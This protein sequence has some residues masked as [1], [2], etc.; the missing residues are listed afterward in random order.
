MFFLDS[1]DAVKNL[2]ERFVEELCVSK[3]GRVGLVVVG[4][5]AYC[6]YGR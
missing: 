4:F 6:F 1:L 2:E 5:L 3:F